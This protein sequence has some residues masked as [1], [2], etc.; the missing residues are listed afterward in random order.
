MATEVGPCGGRIVDAEVGVVCCVSPFK[1]CGKKNDGSH[2]RTFAFDGTGDCLAGLTELIVDS[3][4]F[5]TITA[6]AMNADVNLIIVGLHIGEKSV[7]V[8]EADS[9]YALPHLEHNFVFFAN[10]VVV[11]LKD[12][13]SFVNYFI[14][15]LLSKQDTHP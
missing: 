1:R 4:A 9:V 15:K 14:A 13:H 12:C 2:R 8:F 11:N 10:N 5:D 6:T 3:P 7:N